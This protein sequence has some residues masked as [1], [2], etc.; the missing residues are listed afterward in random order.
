VKFEESEKENSET[1]LVAVV[2][3]TAV[4]KG[5]FSIVMGTFAVMICALCCSPF[6]LPWNFNDSFIVSGGE[7][8]L[9]PPWKGRDRR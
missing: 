4:R 7:V 9:Q 3:V 8:M 5:W 1:E 2:A 6:S